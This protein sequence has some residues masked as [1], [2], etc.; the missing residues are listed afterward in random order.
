[1]REK[2]KSMIRIVLFLLAL[3]W[4]GPALAYSYAAAGKEPLI[5]G[6]EAMIKA[7]LAN[8]WAGADKSAE[9]FRGELDYLIQHHDKGLGDAFGAARK[10]QDAAALRRAFVRVFAAE[11]E[12]RLD[13]AQ[14][15]LNDYQ[16]ARVLLVKSKRF[17]DAVAG[18]LAA[19]RRQSAEQG[20][21]QALAAIGNP[22][23]FGS[24]KKAADADA[25][26]KAREQV[27][28]ALGR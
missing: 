7:A 19:D 11:I 27:L 1:M 3:A 5:D 4:T 22:G 20:L 15:N 26:A 18:D 24:G 16:T 6:R 14:K 21:T 2:G 13:A 12:R 25:F 28:A 10:A 17:F 9:G 8:D 23:L